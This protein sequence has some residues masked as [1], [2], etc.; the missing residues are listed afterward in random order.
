MKEF[1]HSKVIGGPIIIYNRVKYLSRNHKVSLLAFAQDPTPDQINSVSRYTH[2]LRLVPLPKRGKSKRLWDYFTSPVA[3][4]F[5]NYQS[6][7]M[8]A[9]LRSMV[10]ATRYDVAISEYSMVAPYLYKNPD[11]EGIKRVMSV[12]ECYYLARKKVL[13]VQGL[14]REGISALFQLK[15]LKK[16]EFSMYRSADKILTLTPEGKEELLAIDPSLDISVVPHGVDTN[17]FVPTEKKEGPPTVMF[18]G[19]Y[20]HEPNRDA[21]I[22]FATQI[23]PLVKREIPDCRFL[24]VGRGPTPDMLALS[25]DDPSVVI[26]G[27]VDDVWPYFSE[28][29]AFVCPVR[30]GG[31]FRGKILE[32]MA[33]GV[34]VVSTPLGVEGIPAK[35]EDNVLIANDPES[36]ARSTIRILQDKSL[37]KKISGN[38]RKLVEEKYSWQKGVEIL[39]EV[40]EE[41]VAR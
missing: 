41:V 36:F 15:G 39:E 10:K 12:H 22:Y 31:G 9:Q 34:P 27:Q 4:Y 19:N 26:T 1:P 28:S 25:K 33:S 5:L 37:R 29:D 3:P 32:A 17:K 6:E 35:N 24:V 13:E 16:F 40:L 21:V 8:Y 38:A 11:L 20:P 18:L 7:E 30:L 2:D 14:S 23:W